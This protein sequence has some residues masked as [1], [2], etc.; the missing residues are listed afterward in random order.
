VL[1]YR[2][3]PGLI[4]RDSPNVTVHCKGILQVLLYGDIRGDTPSVTV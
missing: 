3:T 4:Y 2:D 1:L